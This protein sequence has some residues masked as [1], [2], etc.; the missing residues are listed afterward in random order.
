MTR[1]SAEGQI[2]AMRSA[3]EKAAISPD[4]IDYINAQCRIP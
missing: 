4:E 3:L 2:R 1:P